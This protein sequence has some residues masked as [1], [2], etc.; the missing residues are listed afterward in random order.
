MIP[1][2]HENKKTHLSSLRM[3]YSTKTKTQMPKPL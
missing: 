2:N 3:Y 1:V